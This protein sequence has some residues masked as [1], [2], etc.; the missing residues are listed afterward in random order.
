MDAI[1]NS[2]GVNISDYEV[3]LKIILNSLVDKKKIT[4]EEKI[5]ILKKIQNEVIEKV[6]NNN[7]NHALILSLDERQIYKEK[8]IKIIEIL[9]N[10]TDYFKRKNYYLPK[11]SE[12]ETIFKNE[13]PIRPALAVIMLYSKIFLKKYILK[14]NILESNFYNKFLKE[15]FPKTFYQK[16]EREILDHPL[17]NEIIATQIAN[18]IIN[19]HGIGF[20]SDFHPKSFKYKI[21]SYLIIRELINADKLKEEILKLPIEKQYD[22]LI[23]VEQTIKF[24]I[25]WMVKSIENTNIKPLL[26]ITYKDELEKLITHTNE[27]EIYDNWKNYYKFL[28]AMFTLKHEY[29]LELKVV[30]ELFKII[31]SKFKI[32]YLLKELKNVTPKSKLEKNLKEETERLIEYFVITFA[33]EVITS[34]DFDKDN[35][36]K[37]FNSYISKKEEE[38]L[39]IIEEIKEIKDK[40][41]IYLSHIANSL[42]LQLLK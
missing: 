17:K 22:E 27:L 36:K 1:D 14:S 38:Y 25:K 20:L 21:E 3:N 40:K 32:N 24:A 6:L 26:F 10:N 4:N 19:S 16:F 41:L 5:S 34:P 37:S 15:Y 2:A 11:N 12:I 8:L 35:I 23:D 7:F 28:P 39:D 9:E 33:K 30:L 13:R 18:T 42:I 31:I 29:M